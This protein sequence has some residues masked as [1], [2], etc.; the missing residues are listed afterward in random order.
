[1]AKTKQAVRNGDPQDV[2]DILSFERSRKRRGDDPQAMPNDSRRFEAL[3]ELQGQYYL[4]MKSK[5]VTFAT[6]PA[7]TGK[8]WCS[9]GLACEML[10]D[11]E[12]EQI[13]ITRPVEGVDGD[14]LGF[15]PGSLEDKFDPYFAPVRSAL[16]RYLGYSHLEALQR[17]NKVVVM[18]L[19]FIRGMTFDRSF[20]LLDE[21][22][23]CTVKQMSAFLTRIGRYTTVAI[24]GDIEQIDIKKESGL[25]DAIRR[26]RN[27]PKFGQI[28]FGE[29]DI[30]RSDIVK[31]V[32]LAYRKK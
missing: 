20:M 30:V 8:T 9:V 7:G 29:D 15:L 22:Q 2:S 24:E 19:Q 12:I 10:R 21:A 31:D 14:E 32:V 16:Q 11:R 28:E 17:A 3:T 25:V 4:T 13:V 23:N 1:M 18:P 5:Q 27:N 6:G 26:F